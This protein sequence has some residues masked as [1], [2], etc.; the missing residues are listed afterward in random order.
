MP[1]MLMNLR[2][3]PEDEAS[4][5]LEM[6][7]ENDIEHYRVPPS[8]F[9]ISAGSIWIKQDEDFATA[10]ALFDQLQRKRA[11]QAQTDWQ[12]QKT[13]GTQRNLFDELSEN[14]GRLLAYAAIAILII[15]FMLTPVIQLFR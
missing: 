2:H 9:M 12:K 3:V 5:V 11:E 8:A 14:P 7:E 6:L 10:K 15:L 1:K 4:A 13:D